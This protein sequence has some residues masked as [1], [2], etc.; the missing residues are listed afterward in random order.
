MYSKRLHPKKGLCLAALLCFNTH[1]MP[2]HSLPGQETTVHSTVDTTFTAP[3]DWAVTAIPFKL[4]GERQVNHVKINWQ[5]LKDIQYYKVYRNGKF[6]GETQGNTYDDYDLKTDQ[7]YTYRIDAY[8]EHQKT[9]SS[10]TQETHTFTYSGE[11][12][13]YDNRN[14]RHLRTTPDKPSGF[15]I[16]KTYFSYRLHRTHKE[17]NG[18][19]KNGWLLSESESKTGLKDSWS[20]PREIA[21]Y[22]DVNFEG[23]GFHYNKKT[24]KV[25]L[26]AHYEDQGG[27]TAAKIFLAQITPKGGIEIGTMERPLG[28]DSRDQSLF[29]DGTGQHDM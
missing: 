12:T 28:H 19:E 22:P 4:Y 3:N 29:V 1:A 6:I 11:T 7:T 25:V 8:R 20:K 26:S 23:I 5:P 15:K 14:G 27:Y 21:F 17:L 10:V 18:K 9:A 13:L 16:G 2:A 24:G